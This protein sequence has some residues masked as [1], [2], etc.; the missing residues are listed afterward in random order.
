MKLTGKK[1]CPPPASKLN[2]EGNSM[3]LRKTPRACKNL[4]LH[5]SLLVDVFLALSLAPY[6]AFIRTVVTNREWKETPACLA[7]K[8][9]CS[10]AAGP[11][12]SML[13]P[14]CLHVC[15]RCR[16][17]QKNHPDHYLH[18]YLDSFCNMESTH[19]SEYI[20]GYLFAEDA[21]AILYYN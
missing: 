2:Q 11:T 18:L 9:C 3:A 5:A 19:F 1:K 21:V 8:W 17:L 12:T 15:R 7:W 6:P 4:L 10:R 16:H 14:W 20:S 13:V